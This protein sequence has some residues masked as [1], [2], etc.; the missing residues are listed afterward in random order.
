LVGKTDVG[1]FKSCY[2]L[3]RLKRQDRVPRF[4]KEVEILRRLDH[5]HI[6]KLVDAQ[7]REDGSDDTNYLVMPLAAHGDLNARLSLY[8]D[9]LESTVQVALQIARA[10]KHAHDAGVS[11]GDRTTV[12]SVSRVGSRR[13]PGFE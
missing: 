11:L 10:L 8:T 3:K 7:V 1:E 13:G 12:M 9:Q 5:D 4:R 6:I 2:A